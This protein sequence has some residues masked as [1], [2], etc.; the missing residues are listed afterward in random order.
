MTARVGL[1]PRGVEGLTYWA[2]V[3]DVLAMTG[4]SGENEKKVEPFGV[5]ER[6][7][8]YVDLEFFVRYAQ[9]AALSARVNAGVAQVRLSTPGEKNSALPFGCTE[10]LTTSA[11]KSR[12]RPT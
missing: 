4:G 3:P 2:V 8:H 11:A 6:L 5:P 7:L 12:T 10:I 9:V 1:V